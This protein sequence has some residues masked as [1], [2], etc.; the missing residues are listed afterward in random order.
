[1]KKNKL[2][3]LLPAVLLMLTSCSGEDIPSSLPSSA[4]STSSSSSSSSSATEEAKT[5]AVTITQVEHANVT[6]DKTTAKVGETVTFTITT[7]EEYEVATFKVNDTDVTITDGTATVTMVEGG[8]NVTITVAIKTYDVTITETS[9]VTVTADKAKAATGEDVTFTVAVSEE[10]TFA[11]F[12]VNDSEVTLGTDNKA[13]VKMVKGGITAVATVNQVKYAVTIG[14]FEHGTVTADKSE[15]ALGED[16]TLTITPDEGYELSGLKVNGEEATPAEGGKATA[17]MAKGGIA[18]TAEFA[19]HYEEISEF[20]TEK[21]AEIKASETARYRIAADLSVDTLPL[22]RKST[23]IDL[24]GKTVTITSSTAIDAGSE[25]GDD[26]AISV[27]NGSIKVAAESASDPNH[28]V[29]AA[30]ASSLTLKGVK[31]TTD[32]DLSD[33]AALHVSDATNVLIDGCDIETKTGF[34]I[35]TNNLEGVTPGNQI[36]VKDSTIAVSTEG[37]DSCAALINVVGVKVKMENAKLKGDRQALI[38]RAGEW[39]LSG[40][41]LECTGEWI[42]GSKSN[43]DGTTTQNKDIDKG[44]LGG[45][46]GSGNEVPSAAMVVGDNLAGSYDDKVTMNVVNSSFIS[47]SDDVYS[48][49][50]A[51]DGTYGTSLTIDALTYLKLL[52]KYVL[53][54]ENVDFKA[55]NVKGTTIKDMN[56]LTAADNKNLYVA[57]GY[58][59]EITNSNRG[60]GTVVD[61]EGNSLGIFN[62]YTS[63]SVNGYSKN[64]SGEFTFNYKAEGVGYLDSTYVGKKIVLIGT[65]DI[66]NGTK[67]FKN[68]IGFVKETSATITTEYDTDKGSVTLQ[69]AENA[70]AGDEITVVATANDGYKVASIKVTR[71][72]EEVDITDGGKFIA[73]EENTVKVEFVDSSTPVAKTYKLQFTEG[74]DATTGTSGYGNSSQEASWTYK[75][76]GLTYTIVNFNNNSW[77]S[78][79]TWIKCGSKSYASTASIATGQAFTEKIGSISIK[80]D[81]K[82]KSTNINSAKIIVASDAEFSTEI[83]TYDIDISSVKEG[84]AETKI[85]TPTA[86]CFYKIVFDMK[87]CTDNGDVIISSI[88]FNESL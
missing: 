24:N 12:K 78:N 15:A 13:T 64:E 74:K 87:Q 53:I 55:E 56:S 42:K 45:N 4:D 49:I 32:N 7:D 21:I 69:G 86:N 31:I 84:T 63:T 14:T 29:R 52:D 38:A 57:E 30:Y 70:K 83:G 59:K 61:E 88:C 36:T 85:T 60:H 77:N 2:L 16:V 34:G 9:G 10:Y 27:S 3:V 76:D 18:V 17:K 44:Y 80:Y 37:K 73:T 5:A 62:G 72:G 19:E 33:I 50:A 35:S 22:A 1:M 82:T 6:A 11:S 46:W 40:C 58:I 43:G 79:W 41:E 8:L 68:A 39:E 54:D 25:R 28:I 71:F 81:N 67:Q 65:F 26:K 20:T 66:Y 75:C 51:T 48:V 23:S 47:K